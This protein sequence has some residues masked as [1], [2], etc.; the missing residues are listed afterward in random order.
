MA[1]VWSEKQKAVFTWFSLIV[2][3]VVEHLIVRARAGTGK[4]TTILEALSYIPKG[5]T[6]LVCAFNKSIAD[7]FVKKIAEKNGIVNPDPSK[8]YLLAR[9]VKEATGVT[10][11]TLHSA[12]NQCITAMW[13]GLRIDF[14]DTR[15]LDLAT[16]V[17]PYGFGK[18]NQT[19]L[20]LVAKLCT[21]GREIAPHAS[22]PSDLTD[23]AIKFECEPDDTWAAK[24]FDLDFVCDYALRAMILAAEEK[25]VKT[26]IDGADMIFLPIRKGW[27][28]KTYDVIIVDE[29]QDMTP[30]QLEIAQG[31]CKGRIIVV[32][33]DRQAIY[34]FRG[35]D[36]DS[37]DRLKAELNATE[38]PL[39]TTYRCA[40]SIVRLA[41]QYVPDFEAGPN[42][43]EGEITTIGQDKL[44]VTAELGDFILS[45]T[46]AQLV[47]VAMSLLRNGK[48][49]RIKG[50]DIGKGI[51]G[52][53]QKFN[54]RSIPELLKKLSAWETREIERLEARYEGRT[55]SST[56]QARI[57]GVRDQ[58][59]MITSLT[60]G[61]RGVSEVIDRIKSLFTDDGLGNA[62]VITCSSIHRAKGLEA[63]RV[64]IL[65][66]TLRNHSQE[67]LNLTYVAIT[68]AIETLVWVGEE[69]AA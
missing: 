19:I 41:Q 61:A 38:L 9:A 63:K 49:A 29:A 22:T 24:G 51:A 1:R 68:R 67:E 10:A 53:V 13:P 25:P 4:T 65:R 16:R 30:A 47:S 50:K 8:P 17:L 46:N 33:D 21:K 28:R 48:R 15:E 27:L 3:G 66:E 34:G 26:G 55:D 7:E 57:D 40:Q 32:G 44:N 14:S 59:A 62:G 52:L 60:D 45:R 36:A 54:A 20:K 6:V 42:N 5:L 37:L 31:L 35:A 64:F 58:A 12:G 43:P 39:N 18:D 2:R 69:K 11:Q 56:F 23:V